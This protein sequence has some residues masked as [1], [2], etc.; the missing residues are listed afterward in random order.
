MHKTE[1]FILVLLD[2]N[3]FN[4]HENLF[5]DKL[6]CIILFSGS[7]YVMFL[8]SSQVNLKVTVSTEFQSIAH[9]LSRQIIFLRAVTN[10]KFTCRQRHSKLN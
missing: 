8:T 6:C 9:N 2:R 4:L 7:N 5:L 10:K 1:I 3:C